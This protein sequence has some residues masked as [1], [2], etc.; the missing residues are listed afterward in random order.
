M[1]ALIKERGYVDEYSIDFG[2]NICDVVYWG[3]GF[4]ITD[5]SYNESMT[6][7]CRTL[8]YL[9]LMPVGKMEMAAL[10]WKTIN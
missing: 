9:I 6:K 5:I 1:Q 10:R 2:G 8:A 7:N 3:L 4:G